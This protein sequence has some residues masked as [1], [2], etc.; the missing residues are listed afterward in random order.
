MGTGPGV[1]RSK[2]QIIGKFVEKTG[3]N[4]KSFG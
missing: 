2:A 1:E 4:R 3:K